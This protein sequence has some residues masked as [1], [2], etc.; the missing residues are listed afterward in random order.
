MK[1]MNTWLSKEIPLGV[2]FRAESPAISSTGQR[3]VWTGAYQQP[4]LKGR[5][6]VIGFDTA[7]SGL[8]EQAA[9]IHRALPCANDD[10][11]FS[12]EPDGYGANATPGRG[13]NMKTYFLSITVCLFLFMSCGMEE[14]QNKENTD[15]V[16]ETQQESASGDEI[17]TCGVTDPAK[18]L[19][20][21]AE[22]IEKAE[23][24]KTAGP[25]KPGDDYK[26]GHYA[27]Q[28]W[29]EKYKGQDL[30]VT[31]MMLGSGG[32]LCWF[33]DCSGNHLV[34]KNGQY[35]TCTACQYVGNHHFYVEDDD[36]E[37]FALN[38]K[39]D[40]VIYSPF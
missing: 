12:P 10:R 32:V 17:N 39:L 28:I 20:W 5:N 22:L 24:D 13:M 31:N 19:P 36:F 15:T 3:P 2:A 29:L 4:A 9:F 25:Y 1:K 33:F 30:F 16:K 40:A 26:P 38:M 34:P 18:N 7:L 8:R 35:E 37:S 21:L 23:Y 6:P 11:A 27:G 14:T